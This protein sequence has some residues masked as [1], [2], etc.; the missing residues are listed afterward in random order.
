MRQVDAEG[1]LGDGLR[2]GPAV[3]VLP[4]GGA[5]A[6]QP[7]RLQTDAGGAPLE[8]H[9]I[10]R[11][12]F[13]GGR[14][15]QAEGQRRA[16]QIQPNK[17]PGPVAGR[18]L[19][20]DIAQHTIAHGAPSQVDGV[21]GRDAA[22][23]GQGREEFQRGGQTPQHEPD[24]QSVVQQPPVRRRHKAAGQGQHRV[25]QQN[26]VEVIEMVLVMEQHQ[27]QRR[28]PEGRPLQHARSA[29]APQQLHTL[30]GC[31]PEKQGRQD[32]G[33][34]LRPHP[35]DGDL[36]FRRQQQ[37]AAAQEEHRHRAAQQAVPE[38]G[39][40]PPKGPRRSRKAPGGGGM[41]QQRAED[42]SGL[43]RVHRHAAA[44][45]QRLHPTI[46]LIGQIE[47][48]DNSVHGL[49]E[50]SNRRFTP[51]CGAATGAR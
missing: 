2:H 3:P 28:L 14:Q 10:Q 16:R 29:P 11:P 42:G 23:E 6:V 39:G 12:G 17:G 36:L 22:D 4:P 32:A 38:Q 31:G 50:K 8:E 51:S 20:Q 24:P 25:H 9:L 19:S 40:G 43:G 7:R 34:V 48:A 30:I 13:D 26:D 21:L 15:R 45:C 44:L 27:I 5:E 37:R 49:A 33:D 35:P 1:R 46:S 41:D 18:L 47:L